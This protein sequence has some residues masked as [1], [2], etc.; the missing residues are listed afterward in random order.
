MFIINPSD[1]R[2]DTRADGR[3]IPGI[4]EGC[5]E[6][7]MMSLCHDAQCDHPPSPLFIRNVSRLH[8]T[9]YTTFQTYNYH[10]Q[11]KLTFALGFLINYLM[12]WSNGH[13]ESF[14]KTERSCSCRGSGTIKY[15][16]NICRTVQWVNVSWFS[17]RNIT[18]VSRHQAVLPLVT[19]QMLRCEVSALVC[20]DL[21]NLNRGGKAQ[22]LLETQSSDSLIMSAGRKWNTTTEKIKSMLLL[23]TT[24]F[25]EK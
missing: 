25:H 15:G 21:W 6:E 22:G 5:H 20:Q 1:G 3:T 2:H 19:C 12:R 13:K 10:L 23:M 16:L 17:G 11:I 24:K 8:T 7:W 14:S 4:H 18:S 9:I